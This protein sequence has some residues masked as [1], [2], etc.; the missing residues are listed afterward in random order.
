MTGTATMTKGYLCPGKARMVQS[1]S[2]LDKTSRNG[3]SHRCVPPVSGARSAMGCRRSMGEL[4]PFGLLFGAG[5]TND[6]P[7]IAPRFGFCSAGSL[8]DFLLAQ[9]GCHSQNPNTGPLSDFRPKSRVNPFVLPYL[10]RQVSLL[11][12]GISDWAHGVSWGSSGRR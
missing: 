8:G 4:G 9:R 7:K 3:K 12:P 5:G 1:Q 6:G 10:G 11:A 2:L